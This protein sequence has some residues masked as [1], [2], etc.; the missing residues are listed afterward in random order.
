MDLDIIKF[1]KLLLKTLIVGTYDV[2]IQHFP[3][4]SGSV[5]FFLL[6][7]IRCAYGSG[8]L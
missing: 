4:L 3:D 7:T 2:S 6:K 5:F 8:K 1:N